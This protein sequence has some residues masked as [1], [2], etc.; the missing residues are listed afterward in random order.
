MEVDVVVV[1]EED[2]EDKMEQE[3]KCPLCKKKLYSSIGFGCMMCGMPLEDLGKK[4]CSKR[5]QKKYKKINKINERRL[6]DE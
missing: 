4:F 5:C 6:K 3:L 1:V 2:V